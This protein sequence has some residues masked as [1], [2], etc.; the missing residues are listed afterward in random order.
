MELKIETP[1]KKKP[2]HIHNENRN[3]FLPTNERMRAIFFSVLWKQLNVVS[4]GKTLKGSRREVKQFN[5]KSLSLSLS[6][7]RVSSSSGFSRLR[8]QF[9]FDFNLNNSIF[10]VSWSAISVRRKDFLPSEEEKK[11][12]Q[13]SKRWRL[14]CFRLRFLVDFRRRNQIMIFKINIPF[15]PT[16][17]TNDLVHQR[18]IKRCSTHQ[19]HEQL[20]GE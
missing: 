11:N 16:S 18:P 12:R 8:L 20:N 6:L 15:P 19:K 10:G 7:S 5:C 2:K 14:Q 3:D 1:Q 9:K 17:K 4:I 13:R